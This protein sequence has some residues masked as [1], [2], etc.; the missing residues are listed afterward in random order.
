MTLDQKLSITTAVLSAPATLIEALLAHD[1]MVFLQDIDEVVIEDDEEIEEFDSDLNSLVQDDDD[2]TFIEEDAEF[3]YLEDQDSSERD[4]TDVRFDL[5][6]NDTGS[7]EVKFSSEL[8]L[9]LLRINPNSER[10]RAYGSALRRR[11]TILSAACEY[12]VEQCPYY[13]HETSHLPPRCSRKE[14]AAGIAERVPRQS[15]DLTNRLSELVQHA[16]IRLPN[17]IIVGLD[18]WFLRD[19]A[20]DD[21][22]Q[23]YLL[24]AVIDG[25]PQELEGSI[26]SDAD[27][28]EEVTRRST[29]DSNARL[30][31][32]ADYLRKMR[33]SILGIRS[34]RD[35][36]R[37]FAIAR[38][39]YSNDAVQGANGHIH[40]L[41]DVCFSPS[42]SVLR[43]WLKERSGARSGPPLCTRGSASRH[44]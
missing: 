9:L 17:G 18:D 24:N 23:K 44:G 39:A 28:A 13:F 32:T 20:S 27:L 42:E 3:D 5:C 29:I 34:E 12:L 4:I 37:D 36:K 38:S 8:S 15:A 43:R 7:R 30:R 40:Q 41:F 10:G 22:M 19:Y 25:I 1:Q 31:C 6:E 21:V 2:E 35:R 26:R 16:R 11:I 33:S 14:L